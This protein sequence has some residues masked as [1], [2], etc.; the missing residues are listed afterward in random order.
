MKTSGIA[1]SVTNHFSFESHPAIKIFKTVTAPI[2]TISF[3]RSC[4]IV[5]YEIL[6]DVQNDGGGGSKTGWVA[7]CY[8]TVTEQQSLRVHLSFCSSGQTRDQ[9]KLSSSDRN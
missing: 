5:S 6:T 8:S 4:L 1:G 2:D 7:N 3:F 9:L